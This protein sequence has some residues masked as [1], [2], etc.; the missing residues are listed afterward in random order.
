VP[1][2][3]K[4]LP[5]DGCSRALVNALVFYFKDFTLS[6]HEMIRLA[7]IINQ[8]L[9][10]GKL[11]KDATRERHHVRVFLVRKLV[12]DLLTDALTNGI[13]NWDI[14]LAKTLSIVLTL[15]LHHVREMSQPLRSA[16]M[17]YTSSTIRTSH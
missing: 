5:I 7:T 1:R 16:H 11:T 3:V 13:I 2:H 10:E 14:T 4:F 15:P 6:K 17:S 8:L 9:E 12:S